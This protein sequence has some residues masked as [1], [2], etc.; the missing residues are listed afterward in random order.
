MRS[1]IHTTWSS[2]GCHDAT[3]SLLA[4]HRELLRE[5]L[6]RR[7]RALPGGVQVVK[8]WPP[9]AAGETSWVSRL[10]RL[11]VTQ[12]WQAA[13]GG[14][15]LMAASS[16]LAM[17]VWRWE[18]DLRQGCFGHAFSMIGWFSMMPIGARQHG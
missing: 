17:A 7:W 1:R 15:F 18:L 2:S 14:A 12:R 3:V 9:K 5:P 6:S 16:R 4:E 13:G 10:A 11:S 8:D